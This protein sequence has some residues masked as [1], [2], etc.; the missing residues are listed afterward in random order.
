[1]K[2]AKS[3]LLSSYWGPVPL[4]TTTDTATMAPL[5]F[6][7]TQRA[8]TSLPLLASMGDGGGPDHATVKQNAAFFPFIVPSIHAISLI[9]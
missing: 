9:Q 5:S 8:G 7:L 1:M 3:F 6:S 4:A 2:D